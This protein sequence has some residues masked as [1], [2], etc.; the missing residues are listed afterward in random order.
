M[1]RIVTIIKCRD[2]RLSNKVLNEFRAQN[3]SIAT[4]FI[5]TPK[6]DCFA[7]NKFDNKNF[8][9]FGTKLIIELLDTFTLLLTPMKQGEKHLLSFT[10]I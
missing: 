2:P 5:N 7:I 3:N 10:E 9:P 8:H 1:N 6:T 4:F